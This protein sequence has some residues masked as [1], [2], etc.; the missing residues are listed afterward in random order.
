MGTHGRHQ[1]FTPPAKD[2]TGGE[3]NNIQDVRYHPIQFEDYSLGYQRGTDGKWHVLVRIS[4]EKYRD[5]RAHFLD[6][7]TSWQGDRLAREF[8]NVP[9]EPYSPV[10]QQLLRILK[11]VNKTRRKA[12]YRRLKFEVLRQR[13][14]LVKPFEMPEFEGFEEDSIDISDETDRVMVA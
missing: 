13:R 11:Q 8:W 7:A 10:Y 3:A 4:Q 6:L 9:F 1:F 2:G 5:L 14:N 12:G